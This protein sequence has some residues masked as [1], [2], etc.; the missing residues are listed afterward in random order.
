MTDNSRII[1]VDDERALRDPV[2]EYLT[3]QGLE[4][5][6]AADGV[7][8]DALMTEA[9]P[10]LVILDINMPGEDGVSIARRLRASTNVAII[11]L[12]TRA[13]VIDRI[14]GL[15]VGADDYIAKPFEMRELLAR[16]RAVLRRTR[17]PPAAPEP[18]IA[19]LDYVDALW[20]PG[21]DGLVRVGIDT[22]DWIEANRDY[23][24]LHVGDRSHLYRTTMSALEESLDP[25]RLVRVHRSAFVAP[26]AVARINTVKRKAAVVLHSG[27]LIDVAPAYL[28]EL[29]KRLGVA[30]AASG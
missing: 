9:M 8:L 26:R 11:M 15:E 4:A 19:P 1:V 21:R 7:Q 23:A 3:L 22:I 24:L 17:T 18:A 29:Q 16:I 28:P 30:G 14:V 5:R 27:A 20:A 10:D 12:T 13:D 6:A 2:A 25:A